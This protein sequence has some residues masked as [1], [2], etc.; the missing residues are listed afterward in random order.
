MEGCPEWILE[1]TNSCSVLEF[2]ADEIPCAEHDFPP[3]I[4]HPFPG[5]N[6]IFLNDII[7]KWGGVPDPTPSTFSHLSD[8]RHFSQLFPFSFRQFLFYNLKQLNKN[9]VGSLHHYIFPEPEIG[10]LFAELET[11]GFHLRDKG[12][13]VIGLNTQ[14]MDCAPAFV[15]RRLIIEMKPALADG[16]KDIPGSGHIKVGQNF[17]SKHI[18]IKFQSGIQIRSEKMGMMNVVLHFFLPLI[19]Q[20]PATTIEFHHRRFL[21]FVGDPSLRIDPGELLVNSAV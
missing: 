2:Y 17:P 4:P 5:Q 18:L 12:F 9:I 11:L 7:D 15:A 1:K 20:W 21:W 14:M 19:G 6:H 3:L 10:Y 8:Q 16:E 13:Q